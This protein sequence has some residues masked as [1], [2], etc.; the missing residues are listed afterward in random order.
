MV[1]LDHCKLFHCKAS[2]RRKLLPK[3]SLNSVDST[4]KLRSISCRSNYSDLELKILIFELFEEHTE[5]PLHP[6]WKAC[7]Y[8][9][10][11]RMHEV[12]WNKE[13]N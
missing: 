8:A 4:D 9:L 7:W 6:L 10:Y 13:P 5:Q 2:Q 1:S 12:E 3:Q 11:D